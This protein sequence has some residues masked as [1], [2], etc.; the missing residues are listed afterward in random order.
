MT[1]KEASR[2]PLGDTLE[3]SYP[4]LVLADRCCACTVSQ[5][6]VRVV[7]NG[8]DLLFCGHHFAENEPVLMVTGWSVY[9]DARTTVNSRPSIS[10][11]AL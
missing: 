5:A 4:A 6:F 8:T 10:A 3:P 1:V 11:S 9:E 2:K 7:M